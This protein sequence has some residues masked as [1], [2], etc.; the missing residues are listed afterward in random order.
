MPATHGF[1]LIRACAQPGAILLPC[2]RGRCG[3]EVGVP[4]CAS[5]SDVPPAP[6]MPPL[7]VQA[8]CAG[9]WA[10]TE[11]MEHPACQDAGVRLRFPCLRL[12]VRGCP[13]GLDSSLPRETK[14]PHP[15]SLP[16]HLRAASRPQRRRRTRASTIETQSRAAAYGPEPGPRVHAKR[17]GLSSEVRSTHSACVVCTCLLCALRRVSPCCD[18]RTSIFTLVY[19]VT[20]RARLLRRGKH[21]HAH[22]RLARPK[23]IVALPDYISRSVKS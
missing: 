12:A 23:S 14:W 8:R 9:E 7:C 22:S 15:P 5:L 11:R 10:Q 1:A 2:P 20:G 16:R 13:T 6:L 18:H 19:Y 17:R 4:G 21:S 3:R